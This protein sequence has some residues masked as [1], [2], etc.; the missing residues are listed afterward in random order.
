MLG[1]CGKGLGRGWGSVGRCG[2]GKIGNIR[3]DVFVG[4]KCGEE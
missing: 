2:D 4:M 3:K 1:R